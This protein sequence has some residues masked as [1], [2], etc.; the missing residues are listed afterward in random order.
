MPVRQAGF[1]FL[2]RIKDKKETGIYKKLNSNRSNDSVSL[3]AGQAGF[4]TTT[5][6]A[7]LSEYGAPASVK[8]KIPNPSKHFSHLFNAYTRYFNIR[9]KRH[10]SLFERPFKRILIENESYLKYM[11]YYI[12]HNPV[13]HGFVEDMI[14]Y[15]WNSYLTIVSPKKTNLKRQEVID[16]F[17]DLDNLRS[18]HQQEH[19]LG[20]I[21]HL[22]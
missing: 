20:R 17:D 10:G 15:P 18:F 13:G 4:Q 21:K 19:D 16:W 3:P 7:D 6:L 8:K 9:N 2:V 14:E 1:H 22:I 11:I 5:K 12:H